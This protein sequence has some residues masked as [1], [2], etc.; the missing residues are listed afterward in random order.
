MKNKFLTI[1][2]ILVGF[3]VIGFSQA[4]TN[5]DEEIYS[6]V[7]PDKFFQSDAEFVS[8]LGNAYTQLNGYG[9]NGNVFS[10]QGVTSDEMVVPTRGQDWDDGG[11]WRRLHTHEYTFE[12]DIINNGWTFCYGGINTCN[13]LIFQF[14]ELGVEGA[15]A[16]IA[17]LRALR[18]MYYFWL[19]DLYGNVPIVTDFDVPADFAPANNTRQEVYDFVE[20]E[21]KATMPLLTQEVGGAAYGRMNYYT[22]QTVLAKLYLN[23]GVYVNNPRWQDVITAA[24][25]IINSEKYA[26]APDYFDNFATDNGS[27]PEFIFAIPYDQ[28]FQQGFNLPMMT[29]H[30]ASQ[31]T[32]NLTAQ[33]WNGFCSLQEFYNSYEDADVRKQN[34]IVGP[35]YSSTGERLV[36]SG[37]EADDPDGPPL[38]F[39]PEISTLTRALRQQGARI[40]KW[41]FKLGATDNLS[42]DLAVFR[43]A[44]VLLMKA[45]ALFRLGD[46]TG[47]SLR[48]VN[49]LRTRAEVAPFTALTEENLLAE[50][51]REMF[52]EHTRRSDLIRFG[53]YN[54]PWWEHPQ[55]PDQHVNIFPIPRPQLDANKNL[56][57][58]PGY[59]GNSGG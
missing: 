46:A 34:F 51:G 5:L 28:V 14:N 16:F 41:E 2:I 31:A 27:S 40:G 44:D 32:Y 8:A 12:D 25:E 50:R 11:H 6:Q 54:S 59:A 47:E 42:N 58:N 30:Y 23:S 10:L 7:T 49:L 17:E 26:L 52:A 19:L 22:A 56:N 24:D 55:D 3:F 43:Y 37:A 4:C 53:K 15:D 36:D 20:S 38:T 9:G 13:R 1:R 33:P 35:Q 29:L 21:L 57:Q 18:A 45:E 39:T 48:L